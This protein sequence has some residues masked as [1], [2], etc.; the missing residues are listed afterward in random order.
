MGRQF[1]SQLCDRQTVD[2]IYLA[3]E[4]QLRPNRNGN[5]Y[6]Q[7]RL[8]DKTG[9]VIGMLWNANES[10]YSSFENGDYLRVIGAAQIYNGAIQLLLTKIEGVISRD[11]HP[12]DFVTVNPSQIEELVK[13]LTQLLISVRRPALKALAEAYLSDPKFM[14]RFT[15]APAG[16]KHHHAYRGGLLQHV[17]HVMKV[18]EAVAPFYPQV[19]RDMLIFGAFVHDL[20]KLDELTYERDLGYS[21]S[22]QLLGHIVQGVE[23]L[24]RKIEEAGQRMGS[25]F[26]EEIA[27]RLKHMV[28]SHHGTSDFGSPKIPMTLE[29][30]A[31]WRLDDLDSKLQTVTQL[32]AEDANADSSW[33]TYHANMGCKFFK[34]GV[35]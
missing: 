20:G 12:D 5:L 4:K 15:A 18:A 10:L 19:D 30:I 22:G 29:A 27:F 9:S 32:L 21:D 2:E 14:S 17:V 28:L 31:L 7:V 13:T 3:S 26:P 1:V 6:L 16:V 25:P 24:G 34:G 11:V 33:T 23:S 35:V 8:S